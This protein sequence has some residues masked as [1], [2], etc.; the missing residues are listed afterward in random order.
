MPPD[1]SSVYAKLER[2]EELLLGLDSE[3]TTWFNTKPYTFSVKVNEEKTRASVFVNVYREPNL[4]R[5]S[6]IIADI[7]HNVRCSLDHLIWAIAVHETRGTSNVIPKQL[8]FPIWDNPPNSDARRNINF[9]SLSVRTA[10]ESVQPHQLP[11]HPTLPFHPLTILRDI[12]N[13]N[14]HKLLMLAISSPA[15]GDVRITWEGTS[16]QPEQVFNLGD[17]KDGTEI[18][19]VSFRTPQLKMECRVIRLV[20]IIAMK[21]SKSAPS[22]ADRDDYAALIDLTLAETKSVISTVR[23]AVQ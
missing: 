13:A 12:D 23:D 16:E 11:P 6:L 17:I 1:Y 3:V 14:K 9:L 7:F 18:M 19:G 21:Y 20:C 5:W 4:V 15:E 8:T 10:I 2:A 22:G